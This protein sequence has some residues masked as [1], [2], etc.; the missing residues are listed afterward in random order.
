MS[1]EQNNKKY[2]SCKWEK[3]LALINNVYLKKYIPETKKVSSESLQEMLNKYKAVYVKPNRGS[4]GKGVMKIQ[5]RIH[6]G[7]IVYEVQN[8][9][10]IK[11]FDNYNALYYKLNEHIQKSDRMHIVQKGI[12]MIKY[13][14]RS[15]DIRVM[16]QQNPQSEWEITGFLARLSHPK[17]IVTNI[18]GG[19][20]VCDVYEL[21]NHIC[22]QKYEKENVLTELK[23]IGIETAKQMNKFYPKVQENGVDIA[24]D[25]ELHPWILE[26]NT[27]PDIG[28][29]NL[30]KNKTYYEKIIDYRKEIKKEQDSKQKSKKKNRSNYK[31][32]KPKYN[33]TKRYKHIKTKTKGLIVE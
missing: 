30:L 1:E 20:A 8:N 25:Q 27:K 12:N 11:H 33:Y 2:V 10:S 13:K 4:S 29:F 15:A 16:V 3:T 32:K 18:S 19:G 5:Q 28:P 22:T 23:M 21:L 7:K 24:L 14:K 17:K 6:H 26:V 9:L 31:L